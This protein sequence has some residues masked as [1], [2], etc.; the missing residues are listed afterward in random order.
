MAFKEVVELVIGFIKEHPLLVTTN[1][2]FLFIYPI[3]D[4][5]LP[6]YYGKIMDN[7]SKG[8]D[9][10]SI[11]TK[12][13]VLLII[14]QVLSLYADYHNAKLVPIM[15]GWMRKRILEKILKQ[16]EDNYTEL[17]IGQVIAKMTKLPP[18]IVQWLDNFKTFVLPYIL[19]Y[20]CAI[21]YFFFVDKQ[22]CLAFVLTVATCISIIV[23]SPFACSAQSTERE[24]KYGD[25]A[26]HIDDVLSNLF[27][28][29]GGGQQSEELAK[30][31]EFSEMY[32]TYFKSTMTCAVK[33]MSMM[34]PIIIGFIVFFIIRSQSLVKR[35][36]MKPSTFVSIFIIFLYILNS[37]TILNDQLRDLIFDWG[38]IEGSAQ[39][40]FGNL[41]KKKQRKVTQT[42]SSEKP[43]YKEGIG[44]LNVS[45]KYP[46]SERII[47]DNVSLHIN[48]GERV[49]LIGDIGS[50][51]ST[52]LKLLLEYYQPYKGIVYFDGVSYKDMNIKTLRSHI[53]YVPQQSILFNRTILD[54]ILYGN[55]HHTKVDVENAIAYFG[56]HNEFTRFEKGL[57][58]HVGKNGSKLSGGQRQLIWCLRV[59]MQNPDIIILDEPTAS[60]DDKTK[61]A[62]HRML[63]TMM[64]DK[65]VI[66]VTH[67]SFLE[68][69]ATRV[70]KLSDGHVVSDERRTT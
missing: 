21:G 11:L 19:V 12:V 25:I 38:A 39:L 2:V 41:K 16:Y 23:K 48:K 31:E 51:K 17:E 5:W 62:L 64:Q 65:M 47:L 57:D 46:N 6:H 35:H 63:N 20:T 52:I 53:G 54:N 24:I 42:G 28:I 30:L 22:L 18:I 70:I 68:G 29:Y 4:I 60:V 32:K 14:T 44:I 9:I 69:I 8:H 15:E 36:K 34:T 13:I 55:K 66:M 37:L 45:F 40:L 58:T 50:G 26:K 27:A 67:D 56:L 49:C 1:M 61:A 7:V 10:S 59:V 43:P 3:Q 33:H